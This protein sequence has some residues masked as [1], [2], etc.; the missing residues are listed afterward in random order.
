MLK[1]IKK[2]LRKIAEHAAERDMKVA[3]PYDDRAHYKTAS[4]AAARGIPLGASRR[5][6]RKWQRMM[7]RKLARETRAEIKEL[8]E[9]P[10]AK[11]L[12]LRDRRLRR[13]W[14]KKHG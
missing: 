8:D 2:E 6:I 9:M 3:E 4:K 10:G 1:A 11:K 5:Q 13:K 12:R 7:R 14:C